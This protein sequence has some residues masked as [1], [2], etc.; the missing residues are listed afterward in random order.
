M[1]LGTKYDFLDSGSYIQD[2]IHILNDH[3][4]YFEIIIMTI[5]MWMLYILFIYK[6]SFI[7]KDLT[8]NSILEIVWT[9]IPA[10]ILVLIAIPSL[11]LLYLT[12]DILLPDLTIKII[13][14]QW[15]WSYN[16]NIGNELIEF[17][18]Y[19]VNA[20]DLKLGDLRNY[21]VDEYLILP[22]NTIIRFLITS[23]DV[24]HS[25]SVPALG[26]KMDAVPGRLNQISTEIY[27]PGLYY[28]SCTELCGINHS[29][30]PILLKVI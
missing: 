13:G 24:I 17:D 30:M 1:F 9:I 2:G 7:T 26:I 22:S 21:E 20:N 29:F 28:G 16:Y 27:R 3:I 6:T 15:F 14:R 25:W 10:I 11:R 23:T 5:V 4:L 8:H 12:D 18:S 19:L